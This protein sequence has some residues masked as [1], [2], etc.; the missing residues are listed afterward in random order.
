MKRLVFISAFMISATLWSQISPQSKKVTKTFF[1]D[2][3]A[4]DN[5]TPAL[6]KK[7]GYTN[8]SELMAF[9]NNLVDKHPDIVQLRYIGESQKGKKIP[10]L[11]LN[12]TSSTPK[13][14]VWM[15][16]GL[17]GNEPASTEGMLYFLDKILNDLEVSYLLDK[18]ELAVVPMANID[19]YLKQSRYAANGLDLNRDQTK[20]MAPESIVI[21]QAFSDFNPEV[22]L[23][24]HE[25]RP[26]R[27]DFAQLSNFGITALYDAMFLNSGN[28]NVPKNLRLL[29]QSLFIENA[30]QVL[31][32]NNFNH[33]PY[34]STKKYSGDIHFN[35]GSTNARSSATNFALTNT[36]STLFEIRGV[37]IGK[38]AFKRRVYIT[39]L[40]ALSYMETSFNNIELIKDEIRKATDQT[41]AVV[42]TSLKS[43]YKDSIQAI[44]LDTN[45]VIDLEVTIRDGLKAKPN[46]VRD[47]PKAYLID[48]NQTLL[49]DKLKTLG[50][51]I[52][53]LMHDQDYFVET[54]KV[55]EYKR[56]TKKYEKMNLQTIKT[57]ISYQ[58]IQ[59]PKGTFKISMQQRRSNIVAEVLEPEAP[60]SFVSFGVLK[61]EKNQRLP[62]YRISN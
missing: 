14:K 43:I 37:G 1:P 10:L 30:E 55:S 4:L 5:T 41:N 60:N 35:Q 27:K 6:Q 62:I 61:T 29:T 31:D 33:H 11:S 16:G 51:E 28:L 53:T 32:E 15:M 38:T 9:L 13:I 18:I 56:A 7:K 46:I 19:G 23:D 34:I 2:Y 47:R 42:V 44:D 39:Y 54:Y 20:L 52:D 24:F 57:E 17:H 3:E 12:K 8:Y 36:I 40:M 26:Y 45:A 59:F 49:I 21:K 50:V 58:N 22:A 25:Y 48:Y